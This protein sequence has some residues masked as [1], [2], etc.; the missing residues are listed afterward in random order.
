MDDTDLQLQNNKVTDK[1]KK[2]LPQIPLTL[3]LFAVF[4]T[5]LS[6]VSLPLSFFPLLVLLIVTAFYALKKQKDNRLSEAAQHGQSN[7]QRHSRDNQQRHS[8]GLLIGNLPRIIA[9]LLVLC[10]LML[11]W[12]TIETPSLTA[13][14]ALLTT[15]SWAKMCELKSSRDTKFIWLLS[16]VLLALHLLILIQYQ[17]IIAIIGLFLLI[18]SATQFNQHTT[19]GIFSTG[20]KLLFSRLTFLLAISLPFTLILFVTLP[21]INLPMKELGL[22]M[23]LPIAV[24]V[25][26]SLAAK[27][28]G[29]EL[30]FDDIGE[31]GQSDSRVL[32]A[33][34]PSDFVQ[35]SEQP[36]YWRGPVYWR[37]TVEGV[38]E[39]S[40]EKWQLRKDF[41]VR[42]KRQY[43][44]FGSNKAL[45]NMTSM[46]DN[47]IEYSVILMPHGEYWLYAL[48]LPA[49]LTGESYLSQDYQLLSIRSVQTMWRYKIKSSLNYKIS[50]KEPQAQ[51]TLGLQYPKNN[52]QIKALGKQWQQQFSQTTQPAQAIISHAEQFFKQG[53]YLYANT[54][55]KYQGQHQLDQF[56]FSRKVGYSQHYASALTL[57]LRAANIPARLVAGYRGAEKVGLTNMV[58]VNEHH[59]HAWVEAYITNEQGQQY[60]QRVDPALWLTDL[61]SANTSKQQTPVEQ[62]DT[63]EKNKLITKASNNKDELK[64]TS[65]AQYKTKAKENSNNWLDSLNQWTLEFDANKQNQ[66]ANKLGIN[67]LLWWHLLVIAFG[68]LLVLTGLYYLIIRFI[69]RGKKPAEHVHIYQQLGKKLTKKGITRLPYEGAQSYFQRCAQQ[70]SEQ[71]SYFTKLEQCYLLLCF[72]P[73][74][75]QQYQIQ[76]QKFHLLVAKKW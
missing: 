39:N 50:A 25:D 31:Q 72:A 38:N 29:K 52:P 62:Q 42:S 36:L 51:L 48:D 16:S 17:S 22:V 59:A 64:Q 6:L 76:L 70:H 71:A 63:S 47:T 7:Q 68:L 44:G 28:L 35:N 3:I 8:R 24:E 4:N 20:N 66:L 57:L 1:M 54:G 9:Y 30:S 19:K 18:L 2:T 53:K 60:W 40:E 37:Y 45:E 13:I 33:S 5:I 26:K 21:R 58:T 61:F 49:K 41:T 23:G 73:L 12:K 27:G 32:L 15:L 67:T 69:N 11:I 10:S 55:E 34:L 46:R 74:T 65:K 43:N 56:L 75:P 14:S